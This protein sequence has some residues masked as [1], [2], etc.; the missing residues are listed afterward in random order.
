MSYEKAMLGHGCFS[1]RVC[2]AKPLDLHKM[3]LPHEQVQ[4]DSDEWKPYSFNP[5]SLQA[6]C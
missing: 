3:Q 2:L 6:T 1:E 5:L 4:E